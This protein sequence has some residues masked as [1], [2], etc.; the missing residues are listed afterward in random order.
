VAIQFRLSVSLNRYSHREILPHSAPAAEAHKDALIAEG[1][2]A[3]NSCL[4]ILPGNCH[5]RNPDNTSS[6][7]KDPLVPADIWGTLCT[8][9]L[10]DHT[11]VYKPY[12][13]DL[14]QGRC[15]MKV[16]S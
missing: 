14:W 5:H 9:H 3:G 16:P 10:G 15:A 12:C 8:P 6:S 11:A 4:Q 13:G 7:C 2:F 1:C